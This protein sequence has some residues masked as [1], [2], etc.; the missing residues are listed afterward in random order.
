MPHIYDLLRAILPEIELI[1]SKFISSYKTFQIKQIFSNEIPLMQKNTSALSSDPY[2][3]NTQTTLNQYQNSSGI[4]NYDFIDPG[5]DLPSGADK[6]NSFNHPYS[7]NTNLHVT[8][9]DDN[10]YFMKSNS[11][12]KASPVKIVDQS[13]YLRNKN[14]TPR[15][16]DHK[17]HYSVRTKSYSP[18][19]KSSAKVSPTHKAAQDSGNN[20]YES[21]GKKKLNLASSSVQVMKKVF[22]E[23]YSL[24]S[25]KKRGSQGDQAENLEYEDIRNRDSM[26]SSNRL[27]T[28]G[29]SFEL[30]DKS[31]Q[32]FFNKLKVNPKMVNATIDDYI[33][34]SIEYLRH[35]DL[36]LRIGAVINLFD[37]L[38]YNTSAILPDHVTQICTQIFNLLPQYHSVGDSNF[39]YLTM[40]VL[41]KLIKIKL[42][43]KYSFR[44]FGTE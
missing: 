9:T 24:S 4:L 19:S 31:Y 7:Q 34:E 23:D 29:V 8:S 37:I 27:K 20:F 43:L 28:S 11:H 38:Y 15:N 39:L 16:V 40:E 14:S 32:I 18:L 26:G 5:E 42:V 35:S 36:H 1:D 22:D 17:S 13:S 12:S 30:L 2:D 41:R 21:S 33:D 6:E 3:N 25:P 10:M 44:S